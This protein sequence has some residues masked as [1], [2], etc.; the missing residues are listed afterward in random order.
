MTQNERDEILIN[1]WKDLEHL[2]PNEV[3]EVF[4]VGTVCVMISNADRE[5]GRV[6]LRDKERL[7]NE[8]HE[9]L[10]NAGDEYIKNLKDS[11]GNN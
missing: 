11:L 8:L 10:K 9:I 6:L 7:G 2:D 4:L 1:F 5:M 3:L